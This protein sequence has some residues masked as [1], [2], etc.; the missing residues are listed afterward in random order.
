MGN[1]RGFIAFFNKAILNEASEV[2]IPSPFTE[3]ALSGTSVSYSCSWCLCLH[4][5]IVRALLETLITH[6]PVGEKHL[7]NTQNSEVMQ[8]G[9]ADTG[10]YKSSTLN[11]VDSDIS[12]HE[13][14]WE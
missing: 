1:N 7:Q 4:R 5:A 11:F 12:S 6:M 9:D 10:F 8:K 14:K 3:G 13:R 2:F